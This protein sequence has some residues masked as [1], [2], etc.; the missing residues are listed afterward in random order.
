ME[1]LQTV[2]VEQPNPWVAPS[3]DAA[4]DPKSKEHIQAGTFP[5]EADCQRE[6]DGW[7]RF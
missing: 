7:H 3:L 2:V 1:P 6:L 5:L 4:Y